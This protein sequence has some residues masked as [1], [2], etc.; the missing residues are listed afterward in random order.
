MDADSATHEDSK[1]RPAKPR[2]L[3]ALRS[4]VMSTRILFIPACLIFVK[5]LDS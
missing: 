3:G 4:F 5:Q 2:P 1:I